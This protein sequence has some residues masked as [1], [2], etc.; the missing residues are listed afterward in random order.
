MESKTGGFKYSM[1][2]T[3]EKVSRSAPILLRGDIYRII[4]DAKKLGYDAVELQ[5]RDAAK[6]DGLALAQYCKDNEFAISALATGLEYSLS[7][8]SMISD[9]ARIRRKMM[10][11]LKEHVDLAQQLGCLV[12]IGCVRG[13]IPCGHDEDAY[14]KRFVSNLVDLLEYAVAKDV[15]VA[16]EAINYYVNNYLNTVR[17]TSD[18]ISDMGFDNLKLHIDTHH[19][20]IEDYDPIEG[21]QY[22]KH[23][24]G[25]VHVAEINRMYPGAG[26]FDFKSF[27]DVLS[28]I[29]YNGYVALECI[30]KPDAYTAAQ[31]GIDYLKLLESAI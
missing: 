13:N 12:I 4:K 19:M 28:Q 30:P 18:F 31:K 17:E 29:G 7:H 15:V 27:L 21:L 1:A 25:Y 5:L 16:I 20:N 24:I 11:K 2:V 8:L 9:N 10:T 14:M 23:H 22:S 6:V 26:K 3:Q